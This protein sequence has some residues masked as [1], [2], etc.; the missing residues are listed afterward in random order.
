[1]ITFRQHQA[2]KPTEAGQ[3]YYSD[4]VH[5]GIVYLNNSIIGADYVDFQVS[6][7]N[8]RTHVT[9]RVPH[10]MLAESI[11]DYRERC[12]TNLGFPE[13]RRLPVVVE[14]AGQLLKNPDMVLA[15][16]FDFIRI[17]NEPCL[18]VTVMNMPS[19]CSSLS[20]WGEHTQN[21]VSYDISLTT[22][23]TERQHIREVP[24]LEYKPVSS[25]SDVDM[26][27]LDEVKVVIKKKNNKRSEPEKSSLS[28]ESDDEYWR[29]LEEAYKNFNGFDEE[30]ES[31]DNGP[32]RRSGRLND[33]KPKK[34][35]SIVETVKKRRR[36]SKSK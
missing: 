23:P 6:F 12:N 15:S 30:P 35:P 36:T 25:D 14:V 13:N 34:G 33:K 8:M 18:R 10:V 7:D 3:E 4:S 9:V 1:M 17:I 29:V 28:S 20:P 16:R 22:S 26:D 11:R 5:S 31:V 21:T 2:I 24:A 19:V 32:L 27:D